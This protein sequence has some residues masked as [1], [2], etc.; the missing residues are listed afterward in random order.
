MSNKQGD[1]LDD[2]IAL[3]DT[4][5]HD[6]VQSKAFHSDPYRYALGV[7]VAVVQLLATTT[8]RLRP[9]DPSPTEQEAERMARVRAAGQEGRVLVRHLHRRTLAILALGLA[10]AFFLGMGTEVARSY[11]T[12]AYVAPGPVMVGDDA[13]LCQRSGMR[14]DP[15][16]RKFYPP[17]NLRLE[18][19]RRR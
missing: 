8:R 2:L 11:A 15:E 16:G 1:E 17:L 5:L 7:L 6:L 3:T 9:S 12:G 18:T 4:K 10:G 14:L 13:M 19:E